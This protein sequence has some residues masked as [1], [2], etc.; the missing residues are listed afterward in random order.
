MEINAKHLPGCGTII[1]F[2]I[3]FL[4][5]L[6]ASSCAYEPSLTRPEFYQC[7]VTKI[8]TINSLTIQNWRIKIIP[9]VELHVVNT[10]GFEWCI[11]DT[12]GHR[13]YIVGEAHFY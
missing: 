13:E 12:L 6:W 1:I 3:V 4:I 5:A 9:K 11:Y 2:I 7:T 8:D 10:Q